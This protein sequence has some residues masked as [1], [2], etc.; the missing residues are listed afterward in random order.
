[1]NKETTALARSMQG[2]GAKHSLENL[3]DFDFSARSISFGGRD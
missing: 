2:H 1:M 3:G